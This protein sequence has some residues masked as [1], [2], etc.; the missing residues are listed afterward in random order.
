MCDTSTWRTQPADRVE[1]HGYS[2]ATSAT[3]RVVANRAPNMNSSEQRIDTPSKFCTRM[4]ETNVVA[5][6]SPLDPEISF[7]H[8]SVFNYRAS[9][10]W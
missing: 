9:A 5:I 1:Q 10:G 3:E 8:E 4:S 6:S 2:T 7:T